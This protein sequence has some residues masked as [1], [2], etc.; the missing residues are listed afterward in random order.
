MNA[1][2]AKKYF[3][4]SSS[5]FN[6]ELPSYF[7]FS[8]ILNK[9]DKKIKNND[10]SC[11][12]NSSK[13]KRPYLYDDVNYKF[14]FNKDGAFAWRKFQIIHPALYIGLVNIITDNNNW[15]LIQDRF[16]EFKKNK[17][18]IC[19]SDLYES[20]SKKKDKGAT[21]NKWWSNIEQ[22]SL[23]ISID[24]NCVASTDITD[25][26]GSIYTHT[27]SWALHG[28]Q[29]AKDN[30]DAKT[31][32][33]NRID[34]YLMNMSFKQTNGIPQGSNL[35]DFIAEMVLGYSDSLISDKISEN[36]I[37]NYKI[38]RFRDDYKIY[39]MDELTLNKILKIISKVLM[40]LNMKVNPQKTKI[41]TDLI[42]FSIKEDKLSALNNNYH[43]LP[44]LQQ[45]LL[46]IRQFSKDYPN[47][48][49]LKKYLTDFYENNI[50]T[51][52]KKPSDINQ[53]ISITV[54]IMF[55]NTQT[56]RQCV[57]ILGFLFQFLNTKDIEKNIIRIKIKFKQLPNTEYL[58]IWLQRITLPYI[59]D[60]PYN[61]VLCQKI[62]DNNKIWNSEWLNFQLDEKQIIDK[63]I[64]EKLDRTISPEEFK[65]FDDYY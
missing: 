17:N 37:V 59:K 61:S 50:Y 54:D 64:I 10:L 45:K 40:E 12:Y 29:Y 16:K 6:L 39:A 13:D 41:S 19:C 32:L 48:G 52:K 34:E 11:Y 60:L 26:Y 22:K 65:I 35:M 63:S 46:F 8:K 62:Y 21:I 25:C 30:K 5:Y 9:L 24:Y 43:L 57:A 14:S 47:S 27:I 49:S 53:L 36:K 28:K 20:Y 18:I 51:L 38:L 31:L 4:K 15:K 58:D 56:Y 3:L 23:Y 7:D 42:S 1:L 44:N 55:N 33:G 2:D